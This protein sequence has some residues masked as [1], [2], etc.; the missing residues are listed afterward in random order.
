MTTDAEALGS[1]PQP[2]Q[3][4]RLREFCVT[5]TGLP[6]ENGQLDLPRECISIHERINQKF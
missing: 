3:R 4:G 2:R 5:P 1:F 6:A